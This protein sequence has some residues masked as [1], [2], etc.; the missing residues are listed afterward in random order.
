MKQYTI[1]FKMINRFNDESGYK[2]PTEQTIID[3]DLEKDA[4][5]KFCDQMIDERFQI[6]EVQERK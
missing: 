5:I 1:Y 4:V 3:A 2:M 6:I